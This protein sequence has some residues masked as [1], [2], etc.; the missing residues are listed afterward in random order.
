MQRD[1]PRNAH[2]GFLS[3]RK[4][5]RETVEQIDRQADQAGEL[6]TAGPQGVAAFDVAELH[7]RIYDGA[8]GGKARIEAVGRILK[9]H[10]D[11][12]AQRQPR[13]RIGQDTA[14]LVAV[15]H[16]AA[17][18]LVEEPHH[19][20]RGGGFAAAGFT[21]QPDAL[22]T[23]YT[24]ADAVDRAE[25]FGFDR[26]LA[27]EQFCQRRGGALTRIFLDELFNEQQGFCGS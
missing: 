18:G 7:D 6:L 1:R 16:D 23:A 2:A 22:A 4:L 10:L 15:E 11:A 26:W 12:L 3:T 5:M 14:D 19:H 21:D 24:K 13:K 27:R 20:H 25:L 17:R 9:Y 8:R